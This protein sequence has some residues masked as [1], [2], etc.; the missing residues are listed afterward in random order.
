MTWYI[1][2][3]A[4]YLASLSEIGAAWRELLGRHYPALAVVVVAGLVEPEAL[5]EIETI[6]VVP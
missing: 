1:T 2:D 4:A 3:R 6:A 5:V